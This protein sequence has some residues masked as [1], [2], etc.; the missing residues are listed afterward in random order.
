MSSLGIHKIKTQDEAQEKIVDTFK[1]DSKVLAEKAI[2]AR[3]LECA[4]LGHHDP[5]ASLIGEVIPKHE[6]Y[7]YEAKYID[8]AG[9]DLKIPT[10]LPKDIEERI[11]KYAI[12]AFQ[13]LE[14]SGMARVDF[15]LKKD[16]TLL[17]NELNTIPGFTSITLYPRLWEASGMA[18][19]QLIDCLIELSIER[20]VR[21]K[22][23]RK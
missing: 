12:Q 14:L 20:H 2:V 8:E 11:Q 10:Q 5:K 9:A 19:P 3:E 7:T 21:K 6:F 17:L 4:V 15:F 22:S 23:F 16:G 1:Y 13:C 18:Y